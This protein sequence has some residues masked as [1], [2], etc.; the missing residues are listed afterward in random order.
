MVAGSI[1]TISVSSNF[2]DHP[3]G[4][5]QLLGEV[6]VE[7]FWME[8][9]VRESWKEATHPVFV[10]YNKDIQCCGNSRKR[11][12]GRNTFLLV[13]RILQSPQYTIMLN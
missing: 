7:H 5:R 13:H 10:N 3:F 12:L 9:K 6:F 4:L 11:N 8:T 1:R 2:H